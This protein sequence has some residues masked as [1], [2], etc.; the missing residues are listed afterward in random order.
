MRDVIYG[1]SLIMVTNALLRL[2]RRAQLLEERL[3]L[4]ARGRR[5]RRLL[6]ARREETR[7]LLLLGA[8]STEM[9]EFELELKQIK[10][11]LKFRFKSS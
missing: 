2:D 1:W 5:R 7:L 9:F 3:F 11:Y 4:A 10:F 8:N 6:L